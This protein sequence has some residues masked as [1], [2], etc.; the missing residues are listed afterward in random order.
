MGGID[1]SRDWKKKNRCGRVQQIGS[2]EKIVLVIFPGD[3][4]GRGLPRR[5]RPAAWGRWRAI[6][7]EAMK[8]V[9]EAEERREEEEEEDC[10]R[11][12]NLRGEEKGID[13]D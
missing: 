10:L 2:A 7:R 8:E 1:S 9:V 12:R 11:E 3:F 13:E 6:R 4:T 5:R